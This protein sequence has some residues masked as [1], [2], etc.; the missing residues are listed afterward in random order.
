MADGHND[1]WLLYLKSIDA[2]NC[3][4]QRW[5][6]QP[7]LGVLVLFNARGH[8]DEGW[9]Y[10]ADQSVTVGGDTSINQ[11]TYG[12]CTAMDEWAIS[13]HSGSFPCNAIQLRA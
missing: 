7:S 9:G 12:P 3:V 2:G 13:A 11:D 4:E 6:F 8:G 5:L 1:R 10:Q